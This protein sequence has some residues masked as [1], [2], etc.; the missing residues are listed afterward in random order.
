MLESVVHTRTLDDENWDRRDKIEVLLSCVATAAI[1]SAAV[2]ENY[3]ELRLPSATLDYELRQCYDIVPPSARYWEALHGVWWRIPVELPSAERVVE[4]AEEWDVFRATPPTAVQ[5]EPSPRTEQ[6]AASAETRA[7]PAAIP[8]S[9]VVAPPVAAFDINEACEMPVPVAT[10]AQD[11]KPVHTPAGGTTPAFLAQRPLLVNH[12]GDEAP[13]RRR[14]PYVLLGVAAAALLLILFLS[15]F[16][17]RREGG[18]R[19]PPPVPVSP[20]V[21][22]TKPPSRAAAP[23]RTQL[24]AARIESTPLHHPAWR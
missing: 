13:T 24:A 5:T 3:R 9:T 19:P 20:L 2:G 17:K 8:L 23:A 14:V 21:R 12:Q 16:T 1:R 10:A 11:C 22:P 7:V 6:P 4:D 15:P 18:V